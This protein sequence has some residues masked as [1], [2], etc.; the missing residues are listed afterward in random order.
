M[1][2]YKIILQVAIFFAVLTLPTYISLAAPTVG[3]ICSQTDS[4]AYMNNPPI[5]ALVCV[6]VKVFN[7]GIAAV[8]AVFLF[9]LTMGMYKY[10]TSWGDPKGIQGAK[11]TLT[12]AV[13]G[14]FMVLFA[15]T[16]FRIGGNLLGL[17]SEYGS[18]SAGLNPFNQLM[19]SVCDFLKVA[20]IKCD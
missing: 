20:G 2:N 15:V 9:M 10:A 11:N 14:L 18:I 5:I 7:Y 1:R 19:D 17:K 3:S 12:Y 8:G 4:A 13:V 6:L 16:F